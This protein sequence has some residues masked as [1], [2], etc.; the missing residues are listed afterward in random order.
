MDV[1]RPTDYQPE[2]CQV[3]HSLAQEGATD[4]EV[5]EA[6]D[7]SERTLY[8]WKHE[9]PEFRQALQLG[10]DAADERVEQSLYRRAVGYSFDAIK[11][12]QNAGEAF[13]EPYVEHV[14]PD[15]GAAKFWLTNRRGQDWREKRE[16][17]LSGP[18]GK[19]IAFEKIVRTVIKPK[20]DHA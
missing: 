14:P 18:G 17:E 6:I 3:A 20:G 10:K 4:R 16:H 19:P 11:I 15:V 13:V 5:A 1:G 12:M 8:R 2:F 9:H 7:V